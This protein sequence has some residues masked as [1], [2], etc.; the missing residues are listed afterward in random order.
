MDRR[1][2]YNGAFLNFIRALLRQC[3][4]QMN[5]LETKL[6]KK[7]TRS[8]FKPSLTLI[9]TKKIISVLKTIVLLCEFIFTLLCI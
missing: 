7:I 1:D 3:I 8:I 6:K 2:E 5:K 4:N 9:N